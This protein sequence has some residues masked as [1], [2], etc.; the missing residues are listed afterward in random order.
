[1]K[2]L[3][4]WHPVLVSDELKKDPVPVTV[5]GRELVIFRTEDG[6]GVGALEDRCPHRRM[7]LSKGK[8]KGD[9]L[10]CPY[11]GWSMSREGEARA[12]V[13]NNAPLRACVTAYSAA[14]HQGAVWIKNEKSTATLPE[15]QKPDHRLAF[16]MRHRMEAPLEVVLDN[17]VELEHS[18]TTHISFGYETLE[19]ATVEMNVDGDT[20]HV[21]HRGRQKK[22]SPAL[23]Y[24]L[25]IQVDDWVEV[26]TQLRFAPVSM[27]SEQRWTNDARPGEVLSLGNQIVIFFT[28]VTDQLTDVLTF[29]Y[30]SPKLARQLRFLPWVGVKLLKHFAD[31]ETRLDQEMLKNLADKDPNLPGM[32]LTRLDKPLGTV[33]S[34]LNRIYRGQLE[35]VRSADSA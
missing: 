6:K 23:R 26:P 13:N 4:F 15:L 27:V 18:V 24:V 1:M 22:P 2:E 34:M 16:V 20:L 11:H 25:G 33:R 31:L 14:E 30:L 3:D 35:P 19:G 21:L 9:R 32:K 5:C 12:P 7:R 28:P 17:F 10:V 8:V 29:D